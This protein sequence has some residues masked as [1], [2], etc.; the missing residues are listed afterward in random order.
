MT[1]KEQALWSLMEAKGFSYG[2]MTTAIQIL[3]QSR[4]ALD[5]MIIF[6][7]D[8]HPSEEQVISYIAG[9]CE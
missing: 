3:G 8:E 2:L 7:Q 9:M 1:L 5:D 6:I 4:E